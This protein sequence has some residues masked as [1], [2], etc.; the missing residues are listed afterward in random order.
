VNRAPHGREKSDRRSHEAG[1]MRTSGSAAPA[2]NVRGDPLSNSHQ[3]KRKFESCPPSGEHSIAQVCVA[4]AIGARSLIEPV[5]TSAFD[6][7]IP[8][9]RIALLTACPCL[10]LR[11]AGPEVMNACEVHAPILLQSSAVG[12]LVFLFHGVTTAITSAANIL[13]QTPG[14]CPFNEP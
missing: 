9:S 12:S 2:R 4:P 11:L 7:F 1:A 8:A 6:S 10:K 14:W 3:A 13:F 5:G